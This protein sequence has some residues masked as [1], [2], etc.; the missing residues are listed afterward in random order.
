MGLAGFTA[1]APT[2]I[3][4]AYGY[5]QYCL[6]VDLRPWCSNR[7]PMIYTFVQSHYWYS[8]LCSELIQILPRNVGF[9]RYYELKQLPNFLLAAPILIL[10]AIALYTRGRSVAASHNPW[11]QKELV[12]LVHLGLLSILLLTSMR[13]RCPRNPV[14]NPTDV[15]VATRL[16][17]ASPPIFWVAASFFESKH[18]WRQRLVLLFFVMYALLGAVLFTNFYP[19]T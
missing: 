11:T 19:W 6:P 12:F 9:L 14:S 16:L 1:V 7:I 10:S 18:H 13:T 2:L 15:Q 17:S 4:L 3:V 5:W 8:S